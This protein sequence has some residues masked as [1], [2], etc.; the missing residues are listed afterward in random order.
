MKRIIFIGLFIM[1]PFSYSED[2]ANIQEFKVLS[3]KALEA[4]SDLIEQLEEMQSLSDEAIQ[5]ALAAVGEVQAQ[6]AAIQSALEAV[7]EAQEAVRSMQGA[8]EEKQ[9][10]HDDTV[11]VGHTRLI[12]GGAGCRRCS[13][14]L[15]F[16][17]LDFDPGVLTDQSVAVFL[18]EPTGVIGY[19]IQGHLTD[20][21]LV[22]A[23]YVGLFNY[24]KKDPSL[25]MFIRI[26]GTRL[27]EAHW[28]ISNQ[29][30]IKYVHPLD[31]VDTHDNIVFLEPSYNQA[32]L[33][34]AVDAV[35]AEYDEARETWSLQKKEDE[36][37]QEPIRLKHAKKVLE[38]VKQAQGNSL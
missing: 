33:K 21:G 8:V 24:L 23:R 13:V 11:P 6:Y 30:S 37:F 2:A 7:R 28:I 1:S 22:I 14:D 5:D 31:P 12:F 19:M 17:S 27:A 10:P 32:F 36:I 20:K 16:N 3:A 4:G 29:V 34:Q 38:I 26:Q 9:V 18:I 15:D 25:R 35:Q